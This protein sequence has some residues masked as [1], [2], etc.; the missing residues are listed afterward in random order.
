MSIHAP[1]FLAKKERA[2]TK[3]FIEDTREDILATVEFLYKRGMW[4][5][6][7]YEKWTEEAKLCKDEA[8]LHGWW[9]SI[10]NSAM[11]ELDLDEVREMEPGL[12]DAMMKG[13]K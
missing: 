4:S 11:Y 9:D 8:I 5:K 13:Y 12:A 3:K 1:V 2:T 6:Y 7:H 10:V